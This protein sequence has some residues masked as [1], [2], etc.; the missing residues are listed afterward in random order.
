MTLSNYN[1]VFPEV[2]NI[3][4]IDIGLLIIGIRK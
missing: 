3:V 4:V 1:R 2:A